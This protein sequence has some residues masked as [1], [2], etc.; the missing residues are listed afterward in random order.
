MFDK[1]INEQ[2]RQLPVAKDGRRILQP[3]QEIYDFLEQFEQEAKTLGGEATAIEKFGEFEEKIE[4]QI[5]VHSEKAMVSTEKIVEFD[6]L[7]KLD[8]HLSS[9]DDQILD[10]ALIKQKVDEQLSTKR[11][12]Q[13][14]SKQKAKSAD[15]SA[16]IS[17][18]RSTLKLDDMYD[19]YE[20]QSNYHF[21]DNKTGDDCDD[22]DDDDDDDTDDDNIHDDGGKYYMNKKDYAEDDGDDEDDDCDRKSGPTSI[23]R[24]K[25]NGIVRKAV[26]LRNN[27]T[28]KA[29]KPLRKLID[30]SILAE[31]VVHE[32]VAFYNNQSRVFNRNNK[33]PIQTNFSCTNG[34]THQNDEETRSCLCSSNLHEI[35]NNCI[36]EMEPP[37]SDDDTD[38]IDI[39]DDPNPILNF[40]ETTR[41]DLIHYELSNTSLQNSSFFQNSN[42]CS[43]TPT[44]SIYRS[45]TSFHPN[46]N[47]PLHNNDQLLMLNNPL[48]QYHQSHQPYNNMGI[49]MNTPN[50]CNSQCS[51]QLLKPVS[52][53]TMNAATTSI[54]QNG[55]CR[56]SIQDKEIVTL[57]EEIERK[58]KIIFK[59]D[60]LI[61]TLKEDICRSQANLNKAEIKV[62]QLEEKT[63][64]TQGCTIL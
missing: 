52:Y 3:P 20:F 61:V 21:D 35:P 25:E 41:N 23:C 46:T 33:I 53:Q 32:K 60:R 29:K 36:L 15:T 42:G 8:G 17:D 13:E 45:E 54:H 4:S 26:L 50:E 58:D 18:N 16:L 7:I 24:L 56:C 27:S 57:L 51:E 63:K 40:N 31:N 12:L 28:F 19:Q 38:K 5:P 44:T 39:S 11:K 14:K 1:V 62:R 22:G 49:V 43:P 2:N 47:S 34:L 9:S 59:K 10:T 64:Q 48:T 6:T 30:E 55:F 37:Y